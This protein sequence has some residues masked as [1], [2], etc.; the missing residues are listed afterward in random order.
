MPGPG[1]QEVRFGC[2]AATAVFCVGFQEYRQRAAELQTVHEMS[3]AKDIQV[4]RS[5]AYTAGLFEGFHR[6]LSWKV[7]SISRSENYLILSIPR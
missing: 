7:L 5:V 6:F 4:I 1:V 3:A 2:T